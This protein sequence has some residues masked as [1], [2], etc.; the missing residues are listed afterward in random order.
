[1]FTKQP[2]LSTY[3][4]KQI[5]L[6]ADLDSRSSSTTSDPQF[7]NV[8]FEQNS[9]EDKKT[10]VVKRAG[11]E[12]FG[13]AL[14]AASRG[15]YY[16]EDQSKLFVA[17]SN[18]IE[19]IN[20]NTGA[21]IT[22]LSNVFGTTSGDV[23]FTEFLYDN[24]TVKIVATDG[25]TLITIDS[26]NT[27]VTAAD[28][29]M[30]VAHLPQPIFLDGYLFLVKASTADIY[31][32][33]LNNPLTWTAGNFISCEMFPDVVTR[34]AKLNNYL[35]VFGSSSIEY[36]WDA[37][38][39]SGS[40]LQRNDTPIKLVGY[41]GGLAQHGNRLY[42]VGSTDNGTP[43]IFFLEDFK[44]NPIS[45]ESVRRY[46]SSLTTTVVSTIGTIVSFSGHDFYV[47]NLSDNTYVYDIKY[48]KWVRWAYKGFTNFPCES[49]VAVKTNTTY[50]T[51]AYFNGELQLKK[52]N[53]SVYQ[54]E[55]VNFSVQI[56]T[57]LEMFET[58]NRK[59]MHRLVVVGDRPSS[60]GNLSIQWT[61]N[62][63]QSFTTAR[64]V[65]LNQEIPSLFQLGQ[66]RRRAF[67]LTFSANLPLR[68][69]MLE[70]DIN[71]GQ[72]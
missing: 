55:N 63:Y 32:S 28:A 61:D 34:I 46:L 35:V 66:F 18:D 14:A 69:N 50:S 56:T 22:T 29:D 68:L 4:T 8:F 16:W 45:E 49:A 37:G 54:D 44:I 51:V 60:A 7:L 39:A 31:N 24:N 48:N 64:T 15:F 71:I 19:V 20:T 23:G 9:K 47:V 27:V 59:N 52:F 13:P 43:D 1:M 30:P 17:N 72:S 26:A 10:H 3:Q 42:F 57:P 40:P 67:K 65:N 12:N 33:D 41:F 25:T 11:C 70:V 6:A 62:D 53:Q 38:N 5:R 36:F 21:S 2:N 58:Y